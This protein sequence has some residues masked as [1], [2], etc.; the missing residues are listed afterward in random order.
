MTFSFSLAEKY[1]ISIRADRSL[2]AGHQMSSSSSLL[3]SRSVWNLEASSFP[4]GVKLRFKVSAEG[5][6]KKTNSFCT[7]IYS[8]LTRIFLFLVLWLLTVCTV[9][10]TTLLLCCPFLINADAVTINF[11]SSTLQRRDTCTVT[12]TVQFLAFCC[13]AACVSSLP[14]DGWC[15][16]LLW[17]CQVLSKCGSAGEMAEHVSGLW[18]PPGALS[19]LFWCS[20]AVMAIC[21]SLP[22]C[23]QPPAF[24]AVVTTFLHDAASS[25]VPGLKKVWLCLV[26]ECGQRT[27]DV[28]KSSVAQRKNKVKSFYFQLNK[29]NK[30]SQTLTRQWR[31][32]VD[33]WW[34]DPGPYPVC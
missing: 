4:A 30:N 22:F 7:V 28:I 29:W 5:H 18:K 23:T 6:C 32:S 33:K 9:A 26:A 27:Q 15:K 31:D 13:A 3:K 17:S 34:L 1:R 12:H 21:R 11:T 8:Y 2:T 10:E 24:Q 19:N 20:G 14:S 25:R 16:V